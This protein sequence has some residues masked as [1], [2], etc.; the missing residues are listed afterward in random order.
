MEA[1]G[2][3]PV[4]KVG[5]AEEFAAC[6][7]WGFQ[8]SVAVAG[9][10]GF[11]EGGA[12][13]GLAGGTGEADWRAWAAEVVVAAAAAGWMDAGDRAIV[14]HWTVRMACSTWIAES[15]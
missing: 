8:S 4:Q 2:E 3:D 13:A 12:I 10:H 14:E 11:D 7:T 9:Q 6:A 1:L 15:G 5:A